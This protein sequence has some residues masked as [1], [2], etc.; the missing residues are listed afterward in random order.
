MEWILFIFLI[1]SISINVI[2]GRYAWK[3]NQMLSEV[4]EEI[5]EELKAI[6]EDEWNELNKLNEIERREL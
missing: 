6:R 1:V 5:E 2:L 3:V 4:V